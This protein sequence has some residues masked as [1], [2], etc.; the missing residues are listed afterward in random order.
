MSAVPHS[1]RSGCRFRFIEIVSHWYD[2]IIVLVYLSRFSLLVV[3]ILLCHFLRD[4]LEA[5]LKQEKW[6]KLQEENLLPKAEIWIDVNGFRFVDWVF[7]PLCF[8]FV[9][10]FLDT[11]NGIFSFRCNR[12]MSVSIGTK[13][14]LGAFFANSN[15]PF[16]ICVKLHFW[17]CEYKR[18]FQ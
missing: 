1:H 9:K 18:V 3:D 17:T 11:F 2:V 7:W 8:W 4:K 15:D 6:N 10:L 16:L 5:E 14:L 12:L 13:K